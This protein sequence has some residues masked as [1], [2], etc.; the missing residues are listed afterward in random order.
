MA[1]AK[2]RQGGWA[3]VC[4]CALFVAWAVSGEQAVGSG[5][6]DVSKDVATI[7]SQ[8]EAGSL[9]YEQAQRELIVLP[10]EEA[11]PALI[12]Q[13]ANNP[14]LQ[15]SR[16][17]WPTLAYIALESHNAVQT[18][19]GYQQFV[20]CLG[21]SRV[22]GYCAAALLNSP[23]ERQPEAPRSCCLLHAAHRRARIFSSPISGFGAPRRESCNG[24]LGSVYR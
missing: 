24:P 12:E 21:D 15:E 17:G 4:G 3:S 14:R 23:E 11:I 20:A 13:L 16:G 6:S 22:R 18:E 8:L 7:F 5:P 9:T 1:L 2:F 19:I 10:S